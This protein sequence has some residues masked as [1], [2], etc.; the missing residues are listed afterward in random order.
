FP[1]IRRGISYPAAGAS[2]P[3]LLF[4]SFQT[5]LMNFLGAFARSRKSFDPILARSTQLTWVDPAASCTNGPGGGQRW[6][7]G[8]G[9]VCYPMMD[10]TTLGGGEYFY[11]PSMN[12]ISRLA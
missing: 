4:L 11:I 5:S 2:G 10:L 6:P 9:Q 7:A 12:F 1:M 3:G 8:G